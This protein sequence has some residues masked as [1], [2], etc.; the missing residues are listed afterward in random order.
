M[1]IRTLLIA[2]RGEIARR[3]IRTAREMGIR[4]IAVYSE[5]D[6]LAPH[7]QEADVAVPLMGTTAEESYLQRSAILDAAAWQGADAI[8]PGYGFL[9]ENAVFAKA[10]ID[11]DL[12]WI[13]PP[14]A[15]IRA[16]RDK[17]EAKEL[18]R[19]LDIPVPPSVLVTDE[20]PFGW[21]EQVG[22]IGFPMMIKASA[23][24]HGQGVQV[25]RTTGELQDAVERVRLE[26]QASF[27]DTT[28]YAEP[29]F[30]AA[31]HVEVQVVAD[32]HG[33]LVHLG[34]RDCSV[35]RHHRKL[36][37][38]APAPGIG[39]ELFDRL[40]DSALRMTGAIDYE[41]IGTVEL[42]VQGDQ[43]R[44][45][46]MSTRLPVEHPVTEAITGL[47]LVRLQIAIADGEPLPFAQD[48]VHFEGHAIEARLC[49][50]DPTADWAPSFGLV[51]RWRHGPTPG[52]RYDDAIVTGT[53]LS[54][55]YD[56]L[57]SKLVAHAADRDEAAARLGR[58]LRE[59][60][61]H[62][63]RTN[64][65]YLLDLLDSDDFLTGPVTTELVE[66]HPPEPPEDDPARY[67]R[68]WQR[69][70]AI[71]GPH[72]AAAALADP[73]RHAQR[74]SVW[75]FV[76]TG[77]RN[78]GGSTAEMRPGERTWHIVQTHSGYA[79]QSMRFDR[80][81]EQWD[82]SYHR[83]QPDHPL[84]LRR[85]QDE[86]LTPSELF[87]VTISGPSGHTT[88]IV[89]LIRLDDEVTLVHFGRR[90]HRC[91]VNVVGD[92]SYVNSA[93]GQSIFRELSR[94]DDPVRAPE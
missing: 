39:A 80:L 25:V 19:S 88:T 58:G 51:H 11:A 52:I 9:A 56:S 23:A 30:Q 50:E 49:A 28:I 62:G 7:V 69:F 63:P 34:T 37:E 38:E 59:L 54:P 81:G 89:E 35:Q 75:P 33:G 92:T 74:N 21:L 53:S 47:D 18:A 91:T 93:L 24:G 55:H 14:P 3:I 40:V 26:A 2:N 90:G 72:L 82:I 65:D 44:F 32:R 64:R 43:F 78:V 79:N 6:R 70:N 57:L 71:V 87:N 77:W 84:A 61:I 29:Y 1:T 45:L 94:F 36:I 48:E 15:A 73:S 17:I 67:E 22:P 86:V 85:R 83:V 42:L 12:T 46:E 68:A 27:G 20:D 60:H 5:P 10:V 76:P 8:H 4:T 16:M 41:G 31:R 66:Q 13:G